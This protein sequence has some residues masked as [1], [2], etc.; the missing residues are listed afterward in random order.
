MPNKIRGTGISIDPDTGRSVLPD[1][2]KAGHDSSGSSVPDKKRRSKFGK[3]LLIYVTVFSVLMIA[4]LF[5]LWMFLSAYERSLPEK[6]AEKYASAESSYKL[7]SDDA[8]KRGVDPEAVELLFDIKIKGKNITFS[9]KVGEHSSDSPVYNILADGSPF[10]TMYLEKGDDVGFGMN[11]WKLRTIE[12]SEDFYSTETHTLVVIARKDLILTV[13]GSLADSYEGIRVK[14]VYYS[15]YNEFDHSMDD[16][17]LA[18]YEIDGFYSPP[19]VAAVREDYRILWPEHWKATEYLAE[20]AE[21][22]WDDL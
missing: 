7:I 19:E 4:A 5:V 1:K 21:I 17:K 2:E 10:Y 16:I 12:V 15:D 18:R 13:N 6:T 8:E 9:R 22:M 11:E 14:D 20:E 3:G